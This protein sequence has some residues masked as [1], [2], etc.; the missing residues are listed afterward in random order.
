MVVW[1]PIV[2]PD[3]ARVSGGV[4]TETGMDGAYAESGQ[5]G[6]YAPVSWVIWT[7]LDKPVG[8]TYLAD[9]SYVA[10]G[11]NPALGYE[12]MWT[13]VVVA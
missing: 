7:S 5:D 10:D 1:T 6:V 8:I 11:V 4:L 3:T 9:G 2:D 12:D 13:P